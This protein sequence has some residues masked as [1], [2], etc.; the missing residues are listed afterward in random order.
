MGAV[1]GAETLDRNHIAWLE[2]I[3]PPALAVNHVRGP[4][5]EGPVHHFAV[6]ALH[7][8]IEVYMRIHELHL[9]HGPGQREGTVFVEL[10]R[11]SVVGG[12]GGRQ[13]ENEKG[14]AQNGGPPGIQNR[15]SKN[16]WYLAFLY[17]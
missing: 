5:L 12:N 6:L 4:A 9:G 1:F 14:Q 7:V 8:D 17:N 15:T 10:D 3:L 13:R 11:E 16:G 2:R